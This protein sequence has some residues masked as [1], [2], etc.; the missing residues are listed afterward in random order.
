MQ[1]K[2]S[3]FMSEMVITSGGYQGFSPCWLTAA[4]FA[5]CIAANSV[6]R[7]GLA[8]TPRP[9]E[10]IRCE[11]ILVNVNANVNEVNEVE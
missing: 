7:V 1:M 9:D 4:R 3:P 6:A 2:K 8:S 5:N 10:V 11:R